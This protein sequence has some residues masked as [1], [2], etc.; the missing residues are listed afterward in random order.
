MKRPTCWAQSRPDWLLLWKAN[1]NVISYE[2]AT[3]PS[4]IIIEACRR[5]QRINTLSWS[6]W[7]TC[8]L[9]VAGASISVLYAVVLPSR[10]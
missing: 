8:S 10:K 5:P 6:I 1:L 7:A 4:Y 2:W 3:H 9:M